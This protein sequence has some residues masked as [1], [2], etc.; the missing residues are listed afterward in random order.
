MS[1]DR[2][3]IP[4]KVAI[5]AASFILLALIFA[6]ADDKSNDDF[7]SLFDGE[8]LNGWHIMNGSKFTAEQG[9]IKLNGGRG[10]LRSEK[11]YSDFILRLE[12]RFLL[13]KQDGGVFLRSSLEGEN[14]PS[15]NYEVQV[16]NTRRMAK[17]WGAEY[18]LNADLVQFVLKPVNEWNKYEIYLSGSRLEVRLNG[19]LVTTSDD[20]AELQNGYIGLQGENGFHEYRNIR[21]KDLSL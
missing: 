1:K 9:I 13:P 4:I 21:I 15:R 10:W 5:F 8:T 3:L 20:V 16:E 18:D 11:E 14:W 17:V 12:F 19:M 7:V 2:K 6:M